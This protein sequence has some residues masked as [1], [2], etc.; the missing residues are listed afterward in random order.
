MVNKVMATDNTTRLL[1]KVLKISPQ[2]DIFHCC[3]GE[4]KIE[5]VERTFVLVQIFKENRKTFG[6]RHWQIK[7]KFVVGSAL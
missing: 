7:D 4:S 2:E 1:M 3:D 6:L 5:K